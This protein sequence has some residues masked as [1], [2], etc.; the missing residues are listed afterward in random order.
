[1]KRTA[2]SFLAAV[3]TAGMIAGCGGNNAGTDS[4]T[5]AAGNST[6]SADKEE[7]TA[8]DKTVYPAG[9]ITI[10]GTGQPQYL[11]EYYDAWLADH[12]DIAPD[13]KIEIV[14]TEGHAQSREKITMTALAGADDDLP[15]ATY[16]D[17]VNIMDL[18]KAGILKDETEFLQPYLD[19]MVEGAANDAA[20]NGK[21]YGLPE[22]V[23]PNVLFYNKDIFEKYGVDPAM[24][25]TFD[26]YVEAGRLLKEK[27]NGEVY[28]SYISPGSRTWR[29]WGRRGLMPQ[30]NARIWD[31]N[32]GIVIGEDEGTKL[33][34]GTLDTL[35]SEGLLLKS[36][37]MEPALYDAINEQKVATFYIG[38][39]WDEFMRKNCQTTSG[40]WRVMSSPVFEGVGKAGAPVSS[41]FCIV[42]KGDN[43]YAGLLEQMW[44][45]FT[46]DTQSRN[47]W[48]KS[49]EA[50]NAPYAN[51]IS[52]EMLQDDFWKEPSSF[53]GGMS[54]RE[55]EGKCLENGATN[56]IVTP[57]D[58]EADGI[59]SAELENYVAGNQ[60]M[61]QAIANMDK[62]L[63]AKI[64]KAEI[65]K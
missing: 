19:K 22:S 62:N 18:S 27:S 9:T 40:Q 35:Y 29:Y 16:L 26:G 14:Q 6:Q 13:V 47:T 23:R 57:Q 10:Y 4:T 11:K 3:M 32:G 17:P 53:Y 33:A 55:M 12:K 38:A 5:A 60:T 51:P 63:K 21:I 7:G 2:A 15:D 28:L 49:M 64:G 39:F 56:L 59:I 31:D 50:Q 46:F 24:M 48:V 44:K 65:V 52:I 1:M 58:A 20:V 42:N 45:D 43:V 54:F 30:A 34:L 41:Y 37:I 61:D 25:E 36:E 8:G